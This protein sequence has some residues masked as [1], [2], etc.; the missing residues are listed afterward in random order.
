MDD[1]AVA[2][3]LSFR[4]GLART[5]S[6]MRTSETPGNVVPLSRTTD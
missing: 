2:A 4:Y 3:G 6:E 5:K 1:I